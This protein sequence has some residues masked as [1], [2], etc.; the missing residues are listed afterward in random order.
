MS[1][2]TERSK[3]ETDQVCVRF[4][5]GEVSIID[6]AAG[7]ADEEENRS[8]FVRRAAVAAANERIITHANR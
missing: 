5:R 1:E 4:T 2:E 7:L 3:K 8:Q 6:A